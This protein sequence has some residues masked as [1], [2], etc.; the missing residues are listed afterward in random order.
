MPIEDKQD[1]EVVPVEIVTDNKQDIVESVAKKFPKI[2]PMN[3]KTI[4][5]VVAL[6]I[7]SVLIFAGFKMTQPMG[8]EEVAAQFLKD[9]KDG[10]Y[11]AA[12]ELL[13]CVDNKLLTKEKFIESMK[14]GE[15]KGANIT[16]YLLEESALYN[17]IYE[18]GNSKKQASTVIAEDNTSKQIETQSKTY[19]VTIVREDKNNFS[20]FLGVKNVSQ[21]NREK[22]KV[23][24]EELYGEFTLNTPYITDD[25]TV[26]INGE[27]E[28]SAK[29]FLYSMDT[30]NNTLKFDVFA[31]YSFNI[32]IKGKD[33]K[34]VTVSFDAS[35]S[36]PDQK[37]D[38]YEVSD[39]LKE[40]TEKV[41]TAFNRADIEATKKRSMAPYDP[42]VLKDSSS[43]GKLE[44][45]IDNL[46]FFNA[47]NS[48]TLD[49]IEFAS[50]NLVGENILEIKAVETW[51]GKRI[52]LSDGRVI[53]EI[54]ADVHTQYYKLKKQDNGNWMIV[55]GW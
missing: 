23:V 15:K 8:P 29:D 27:P 12:Y 52:N 18:Q 55:G 38:K 28:L 26:S 53:D 16:D 40:E 11:A 33:I 50:V 25:M 3:K 39:V 17:K 41:V 48:T 21:T 37:I 19:D 30:E 14:A 34:P 24:L 43:W 6:C 22:W 31:Y 45:K 44:Q 5:I 4:K 10:D 35:K 2:I 42:Y 46:I 7:L 36:R 32:T 20:T 49:K 51:S 54:K 1:T 47:K 13:E 9:M